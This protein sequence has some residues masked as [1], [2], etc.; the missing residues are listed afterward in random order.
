[1]P[2]PTSFSLHR[3]IIVFACGALLSI[4]IAGCSPQA[5][6]LAPPA[7]PPPP[8]PVVAL[9]HPAAPTKITTASWYGPGFDG[10]TTSSGEVY[11]QQ[12]LTAASRT[13]PIGAHAKV[14]NLKT[15]KSVVVRINDH[16][17]YVHGRGIDLSRAAAKK[18]GMGH[19]GT[20]KVAVTRVDRP[21]DEM[22]DASTT[23]LAKKH[24]DRLPTTPPA[25]SGGAMPP[26]MESSMIPTSMGS[27]SKEPPAAS[28]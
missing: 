21:A 8:P 28:H 17:P 2:I 24:D 19:H 7:L 23:K 4:A 12:A 10:H 11:H 1:M 22:P 16:G 15:G 3:S 27:S 9:P 13:L 5:E 18:I 14:T 26:V 25:G 20:A 6:T